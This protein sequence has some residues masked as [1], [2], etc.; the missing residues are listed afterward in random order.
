[1]ALVRRLLLVSALSVLAAALAPQSG[2]AAA[3]EPRLAEMGTGA[4][5]GVYFPVGVALC[6]LPNQ[7]RRDH[8]LRCA[9]RP[10]G[11]SESNIEALRAAETDFA[12]VQSDTQAAALAGTGSFAGKA[13]FDGLRSVMSLHAEP[14]TI[15]ARADAGIARLEDLPGHRVALGPA[16]SG[17]RVLAEALVAALGWSPDRLAALPD[18]AVDAQAAALCAGDIDA[19][20][21]AV[22]HPARTVQEAANDCDVVLVPVTGPAVET[23]LAANPALAAAAIPGGLYRGNPQPVESFGAV[24]TLVTRADVAEDVVR[25]V[26]T[27]IYGDFPMLTGL[28]PALGGLQARATATEGLTAPLHPAAEAYFRAQGW[29]P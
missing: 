13:A 24:A 19:F 8:G 14:L 10:S 15:V 26:V 27:G 11:G 3:P 21:F 2:Q 25:I 9:A 17:T 18:V 20:V 5:T 4:V 23:L 29:L 28:H 12:I 1:M 16:G 22:G 6:R 7:G